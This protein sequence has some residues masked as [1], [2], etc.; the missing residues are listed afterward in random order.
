[1]RLQQALGLEP[2]LSEGDAARLTP[3]GIDPIEGVIDYRRPNFLGVRS[4][5]SL[6]R[7]FGRNAFNAPVGMSI[8]AFADDVDP[9]EAK[10]RWQQ[11]LN[12]AL[13]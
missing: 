9:E 1:M 8:H 7:F 10:Q 13:G 3:K 11:W 5:D 12:A 2:Q 4:A 6:Y